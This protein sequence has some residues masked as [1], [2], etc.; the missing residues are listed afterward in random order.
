VVSLFFGLLI[1]TCTQHGD[2][3]E[4]NVGRII[5]SLSSDEL[6][7]RHA[8]A[9]E[10]D[11][12][13]DFI[14]N[15]FERIGLKPLPGE[16]DFRQAFT[17][18]SIKP[19]SANI[20]INGSTVKEQSYFNLLKEES[21]SWNNS[22]AKVN[23]IA[24]DD[25]YR[26]KFREYISNDEHNLIAVHQDHEK[27]FQRYRFY[28]Q[29]S[30]RSLELGKDPND[31]FVLTS[32]DINSYDIQVQNKIEPI[33]LSNIAGMIEGRKTNE[34]VL[35]TAHYDHIGI[36]S[37]VEEDSVANGANDNASGVAGV[38][39]LAQYF[40][41]QKKPER[42]IYFV[43]FTAEEQGGYGS[44]YF[45]QQVDPEQITAMINIEMIGKPALEGPN[46]GWITGFEHSDLGQIMQK[47]LADSSF[48][49]YPDP[50]PKQN[51][52]FRSDNAPFA[53]MGIPAHS[54]STTPIDVDQDY[55]RVTDEFNSLDIEHTTNTIQAIANG[56]QGIIYGK[57]TPQRIDPESIQ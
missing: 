54:I 56:T 29:R 8:F 10:I 42:S 44:K 26:K 4:D 5:K 1:S 19:S 3:K 27:W 39:A 32:N 28:F 53:M 57:H 40:N 13:A 24:Q 2:I 36:I 43:A 30:N 14:T 50:Y 52:F 12:A 51:L 47:N 55:H 45:A 17:V 7:G 48:I 23:Y 34:I 15:E 31:V 25:N 37:P 38:I 20:T 16:V 46:T 21:I 22:G 11:Q 9:P 18:H 41:K 33:S 49:F 6:K 35:Y